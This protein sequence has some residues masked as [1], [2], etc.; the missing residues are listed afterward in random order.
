MTS[1]LPH[2]FDHLRGGDAVKRS[3][4][5][6]IHVEQIALGFAAVSVWSYAVL[7]LING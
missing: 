7:T 2:S 3:A 4:Q 5:R 6:V 1:S